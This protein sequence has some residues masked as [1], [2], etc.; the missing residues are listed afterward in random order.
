VVGRADTLL[1]RRGRFD[2]S[3][4]DLICAALME[5]RDAEIGLSPGFWWGTSL[6][7]GLPITVEAIHNMTSITYPEVCRSAI[8]GQRLKDILEDVA[9]NL[10][11]PD[12]YYQQG[13][14]MIRCGG[15]AYTIDPRK[16]AGKRI[17]DMRLLRTDQPIEPDKDYTVASW[18][19]ANDAVEG[20]PIWD[21]VESY[22]ARK[23]TVG[24]TPASVVKLIEG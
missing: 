18:A 13:G 1:Y 5:E 6:L 23:A 11:N 7:S 2:C 16:P 14:D 22:I 10:F 3:V 17:A 21:V 4:D 20:P 12:P 24:A 19:C 8:K 9:D 15:V